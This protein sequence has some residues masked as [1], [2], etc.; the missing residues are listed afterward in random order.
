M[1]NAPAG[2]Q[3][4]VNPSSELIF[5]RVAGAGCDK[6]SAAAGPAT[7]YADIAST[8]TSVAIALARPRTTAPLDFTLEASYD[9]F[10][11]DDRA[12][13]YRKVHRSSD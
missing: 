13:V 11:D 12:G 10:Y 3:T 4:Y 8:M 1:A 9:G 6:A 2:T 7:T 5:V